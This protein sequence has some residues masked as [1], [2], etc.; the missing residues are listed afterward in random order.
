MRNQTNPTGCSTDKAFEYAKQKIRAPGALVI[1]G[2]QGSE[3]SRL[4]HRLAAS[5]GPFSV[6]PL[7][8]IFDQ[9]K[10]NRILLKGVKTVIVEDCGPMYS[11]MRSAAF[12]KKLKHLITPQT[13]RITP[14]VGPQRIVRVPKFIFCTDSID[15]LDIVYLHNSRFHIV[16]LEEFAVKPAAAATI[17]AWP[18]W[19]QPVYEVEQLLE[20]L[21]SEVA[22]LKADMRGLLADRETHRKQLAES[23]G[24]P[25]QPV[26]VQL[27]AT[28][29]AQDVL[30]ERRR[31]V[32]EVGCTHEHDDGHVNDE[33]AALSTFYAMPDATRDWDASSTSYGKTL[34]EAIL[35]HRWI[36]TPGDRRCELVKAGALILAEIERLDRAAHNIKATSQSN[37][38]G[39]AS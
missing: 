28:K 8:H 34:G 25:A 4:A 11:P 36:G 23:L 12:A 19:R 33:L 2:P 22:R 17:E 32:E 6:I 1:G 24:K 26:E 37:L 35:P 38:E 27:L 16:D 15:F 7:S 14:K 10:L 3:K 5:R 9:V 13:I 18:I 29:A 30:A 39:S 20:E 31:Q 21:Q